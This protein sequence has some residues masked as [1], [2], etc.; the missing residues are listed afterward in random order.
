MQRQTA[1]TAYL[2]S[3]QLLL[4]VIARQ[5]KTASGFKLVTSDFIVLGIRMRTIIYIITAGQN[6][7]RSMCCSPLVS[8]DSRVYIL[9]NLMYR[10]K[11]YCIKK[12][13]F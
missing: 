2:S 3:K 9:C 5:C 4:F 13:F 11:L 6:W 7:A 10:R 1:V 12:V 8:C